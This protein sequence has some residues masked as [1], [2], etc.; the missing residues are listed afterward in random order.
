VK[1]IRG[2]FDQLHLTLAVSPS[3]DVTHSEA[4]GSKEDMAHWP[5]LQ[6]EVEQWR[7]TPFERNGHAIAAEV[8]EYIDLVPPE[9]LPKVHVTPPALLP[10]SKVSITLSRSGCFGSCPA[11]SVSVWS[12]GTIN[13]D[14]KYYVAATGKHTA[15]ID[16]DAVR[17][18]AKQFIAAGFYSMD[19]DYSAS[20]TDMPGYSLSIDID[21][22]SKSISDYVGSWVGMPA[23]ISDLEDEVDELANTV[24]WIKAADGL[25]QALS[26]EKFNFNSAEA[27]TLFKMA[28]QNDQLATIQELLATAMPLQPLPQPKPKEAYS[29][30]PFQHVGFLA[31]AASHPEVLKTLLLANVSKDDQ[32]DKDLA[33]ANAAHSGSL[34]SVRALIAYGA[35]PNADFGKLKPSHKS[36]DDDDPPP[37]PGSILIHAAES[38][39]PEVIREILKYHPKLE[40][41]GEGG[42]TAIFAAAESGP[43]D[44]DDK[45]AECVRLLA[46]AGANVNARDNEGNTPLHETYL[47][48]VEEELL[49]LGAN[50]NARNNDGETPIFTTVDDDAILLY[51]A[52]GADLSLRNNAGQ[53][54]LEANKY[55][56]P[57]RTEV[58]LQAIHSQSQNRTP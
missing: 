54:A 3:G 38:G 19:E 36:Q 9:R 57:R 10:T 14:G 8:E 49:K 25:V 34:E 2:G 16:P 13:F 23:V 29:A 27:Q 12:D 17:S 43:E 18:L 39:N 35:H 31:A 33:L 48:D 46:E 20:V 45:R 42:K 40:I 58:L 47:T 24:R 22:H 52:H 11:Y 4:S 53:T 44:T 1:G 51:A 28:A 26:A 56:G 37:G 55:H 5:E 6:G 30:V 21:G 15:T 50:V 7:F 41:R 32:P